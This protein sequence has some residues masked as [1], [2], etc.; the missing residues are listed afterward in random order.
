MNYLDRLKQIDGH[1]I[2]AH[3]PISEPT[4]PPKAPSVSSVSSAQGVNAKTQS[5]KTQAANDDGVTRF[6]WL[7]YF[8]DRNPLTV[9]F[10]PEVTHAG[11]LACYPDAVAAEPI[12]LAV[13]LNAPPITALNYPDDR[14][15]CR[16]CKN[17]SG[18]VCTVAKPGGIVSAVMGYRPGKMFTE[19]LHRCGGFTERANDGNN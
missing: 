2:F 17:L 11:A 9:T 4:E 10:S 7:M 14:R 1:R 5:E 15:T 19:Q 13:E 8:I 3:T 18:G 16:Q 6:I 12:D